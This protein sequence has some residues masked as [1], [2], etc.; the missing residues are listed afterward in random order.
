M[1]S[2]P[3]NL[4]PADCKGVDNGVI[5]Y[6]GE[7]GTPLAGNRYNFTWATAPT[8]SDPKG[9]LNNV[10]TT[11]PLNLTNRSAGFYWITITDLNNCRFVDSF[12]LDLLRTIELDKAIVN[13]T[14][15][16]RADGSIN[17]A[18][19]ATPPFPNPNFTFAWSPTASP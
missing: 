8:Q 7:G 15:S 4:T 9:A 5:R 17:A 13:A 19:V 10:P 6:T 1:D 12:E 2:G 11:N 14:C 18:A 3:V 16:Y